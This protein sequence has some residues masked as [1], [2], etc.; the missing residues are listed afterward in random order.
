MLLVVVVGCA[1]PDQHVTPN[2]A[3]APPPPYG[4]GTPQLPPAGAPPPPYGYPAPEVYQTSIH[5]SAGATTSS[6]SGQSVGH[7]RSSCKMGSNGRQACGYD[8]KIGSNGIAACANAPGGT[9]ALGSD[10]H[11]Y[12]SDARAYRSGAKAECHLNADGSQSCGYNCKFGRGGW[13][14]ASEPD[15]TCGRNTDGTFTCS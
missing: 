11:V 2:W 9:C 1:A 7:E 8:C 12:C 14:C 15:G 6:T 4:Y 13:Y 3:A 5:V 10:G